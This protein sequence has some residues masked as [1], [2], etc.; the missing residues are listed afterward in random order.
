MNAEIIYLGHSAFCVKTSEHTLIFD[1]YKGNI[2]NG[3]LERGQIDLDSLGGGKVI[4]FSSHF[5]QD[6]FSMKIAREIGKYKDYIYVLGGFHADYENCVTIAPHDTQEING[7]TITTAA[8]TD[9][10]VCYLVSCDGLNI[11][12]SGDNA[13]W[14]D[15]EGDVSYFKEI[16]YIADK[17]LDIDIAFVPVCYFSGQR[18]EPMTRGAV[19][20]IETLEPGVT[21]PIHGN[22]REYLY[23]EFQNEARELGVKRDI[24]CMEKVGERYNYEGV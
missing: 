4:F 3:V 13:N 21:F 7:V 17:G 2:E 15:D 16:D 24:V 23:K 1:Y 18:S 9:C 5:H 19:Y 14:G 11:F 22:G 12:H 8:S 6:H 20:A 10:G